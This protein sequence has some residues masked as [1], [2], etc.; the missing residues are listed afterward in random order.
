MQIYWTYDE[1]LTRLRRSGCL[2]APVRRRPGGRWLD[3]ANVGNASACI[4]AIMLCLEPAAS[5]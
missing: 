1:P 2:V 3:L 5:C 4:A